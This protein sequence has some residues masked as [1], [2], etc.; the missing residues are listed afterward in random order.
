MNKP[1]LRNPEKPIVK[2]N[3][4]G[5]GR[6]ARKYALDTT[7]T[8]KRWK[9]VGEVCECLLKP[10]LDTIRTGCQPKENDKHVRPVIRIMEDERWEQEYR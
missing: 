5:P 3:E 7:D 1:W 10:C 9:S 2:G 6:Y 8:L 4:W